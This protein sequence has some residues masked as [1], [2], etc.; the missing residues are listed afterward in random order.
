M[1][2][3]D[4]N[5]HQRLTFTGGHVGDAYTVGRLR[6]A[7]WACIH[8][9]RLATATWLA[10]LNAHRCQRAQ[11]LSSVRCARLV[12]DSFEVAS[13]PQAALQPQIGPLIESFPYRPV[14]SRTT[15]SK[16][17]CKPKVQSD[18]R[19]GRNGHEH[20]LDGVARRPVFGL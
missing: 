15:P 13:G 16:K 1:S 3:A 6:E 14:G 19:R 12:M 9:H 11:V 17:A 2:Y 20:Q 7:G 5:E 10:K 18:N 4:R 8:R